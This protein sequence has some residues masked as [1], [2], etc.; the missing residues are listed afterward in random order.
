MKKLALLSGLCLVGAAAY[1]QG[2]LNFNNNPATVG[3]TGA[4][5]FMDGV[6][7][8][9]TQARAALIGGPAATAT[10]YTLTQAGV[11]MLM[12]ANPSTPS[13]MWVNF[14]TGTSSALGAGFVSVGSAGARGLSNVD[15]G[16][17]AL[18][19]VV[20]WT[21]NYTTWADAWTAAQTDL[22]VKIGISN[23]LTK[24]VTT[25]PSDTNVPLLTGLTSFNLVS[26]PE[27]A[28]A[29]IV[30]MGLASLLVFRRRK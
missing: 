24:T 18:V 19:Q 15:Y 16:G 28:T 9:G 4:P 30:G 11:N 10:P 27:P 8:S 7:V 3:G 22:S 14:R 2:Q 12:T 17:S 25:G 23:P 1:G 5:I 20:A 21:G 29:A 26:V 6:K 13:I